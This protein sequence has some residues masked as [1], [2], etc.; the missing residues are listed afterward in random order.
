MADFFAALFRGVFA[1]EFFSLSLDFD[2]VFETGSAFLETAALAED[3]AF[4]EAAFCTA[5]FFET[6]FAA[7]LF[8]FPPITCN[9]NIG[10]F[11][12]QA[13]FSW[14]DFLGITEINF[15]ID[16]LRCDA[17]VASTVLEQVD[18]FC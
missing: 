8:D 3:A 16:Y 6:S 11:F 10:A 7:E 2:F 5:S 15:Q 1:S 13:R 4:F 9:Y 14:L 17:S 12:L 18:F